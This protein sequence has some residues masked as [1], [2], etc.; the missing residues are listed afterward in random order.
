MCRAHA[1]YH[2][3]KPGQMQAKRSEQHAQNLDKFEQK[4]VDKKKKYY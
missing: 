3:S 1:S 2:L 4:Y